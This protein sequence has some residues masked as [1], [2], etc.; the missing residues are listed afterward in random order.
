MFDPKALLDQNPHISP[1]Q[2]AEIMASPIQRVREAMA[3]IWQFSHYIIPALAVI[4]AGLTWRWRQVRSNSAM[5]SDTTRSPLRAPYGAR[6]R[7]R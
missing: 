4:A 3:P 7:G 2:W 1:Q 6:H 5:D